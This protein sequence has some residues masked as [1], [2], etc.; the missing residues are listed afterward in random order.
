LTEDEV[1]FELG[2][3]FEF[4]HLRHARLESPL[5]KHGYKAWSCL[6]RRPVVKK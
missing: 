1:R 4:V 3:L 5:N 2:R 6:M